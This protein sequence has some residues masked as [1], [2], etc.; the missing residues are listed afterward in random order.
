MGST[1][2]IVGSCPKDERDPAKPTLDISFLKAQDECP[3]V[4]LDANCN[5]SF[6]QGPSIEDAADC[7]FG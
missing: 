4:E 5:P 3:A 1:S 2:W 6:H 7:L